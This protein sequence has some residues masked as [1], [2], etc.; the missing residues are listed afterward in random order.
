MVKSLYRKVVS[1]LRGKEIKATHP[2]PQQVCLAA[3]ALIERCGYSRTAMK[4]HNGN[5]SM[6][7]A[8]TTA[9]FECHPNS[10]ASV[11]RFDLKENEANIKCYERTID[12]LSQHVIEYWRTN[13]IYPHTDRTIFLIRWSA[14]Y[15]GEFILDVL[16]SAAKR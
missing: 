8:I 1:R 9:I 14:N 11:T 10:V 3:A 6:V 4:N 12:F 16:R 7:G 2:T 13:P 5:L 15:N